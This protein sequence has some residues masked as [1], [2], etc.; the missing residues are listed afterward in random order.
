M[1][2]V[3]F[4]N[5]RYFPHLFLR[6]AE[7]TALEQLP[8]SFKDFIYP[9]IFLRPWVNSLDLE[10]SITRIVKAFPN[11]NYFIELDR[12]ERRKDTPASK[13]FQALCDPT[14]GYKSLRDFSERHANMFL[15]INGMNIQSNDIKAI[16]KWATKCNKR[17]VVSFW[18][19]DTIDMGKFYDVASIDNPL[20][21]VSINA[22]WSTDILSKELK[23]TSLIQGLRLI[24]LQPNKKIILIAS[25]FPEKFDTL[26]DYKKENGFKMVTPI[27][28][29]LL[30]KRVK[31]KFN[32]IDL[33]YG[34]WCSSREP[35]EKSGGTLTTRID[36]CNGAYWYSRRSFENRNRT[37]SDLAMEALSDIEFQNMPE[38]WGKYTI[39]NI[40]L[41]DSSSNYSMSKNAACR[42]N[43][44]LV[45]QIQQASATPEPPNTEEYPDD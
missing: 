6:P 18:L 5:C 29:Y 37:Y 31:T 3:P 4:D 24:G 1:S 36:Y 28:E 13:Q 19:V 45:A 7:M 10:K 21:S 15:N 42:I 23:I 16:E 35:K 40:P 8:A 2:Q 25:S 14:S 11:R 44:H 34:D 17:V 32:D 43:M 30:F 39:S 33:V 41:I 20:F 38:S 12:Y 22:G 9:T 26:A 27:K